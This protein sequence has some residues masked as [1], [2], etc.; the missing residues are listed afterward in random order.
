MRIVLVLMI[1]TLLTGCWPWLRQSGPYEFSYPDPHIMDSTY[2]VS[3]CT[4]QA[5]DS[6]MAASAYHHKVST[7]ERSFEEIS[8]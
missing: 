5:T 7:H 1:L 2:C 8:K 3:V 6:T 4:N